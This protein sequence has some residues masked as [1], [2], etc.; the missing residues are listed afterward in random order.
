MR[1][2]FIV[3]SGGFRFSQV[4]ILLS[5]AVGNAGHSLKWGH[6]LQCPCREPSTSA[7]DV[8]TGCGNGEDLRLAAAVLVE[9]RE[10]VFVGAFI[11]FYPIDRMLN[12]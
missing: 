2:P 3:I 7:G 10:K 11:V 9:W 1:T 12:S 8:E 5:D 6:A 4:A